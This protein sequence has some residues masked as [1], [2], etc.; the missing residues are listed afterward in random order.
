MIRFCHFGLSDLVLVMTVD[1]GFSGQKFMVEQVEK[2]KI[3]R[4]ELKKSIKSC[5]PG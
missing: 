4:S 2:I 1:P 5:H 3:I